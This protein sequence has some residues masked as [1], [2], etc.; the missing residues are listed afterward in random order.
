[1]NF[2]DAGVKAGDSGCFYTL[3]NPRK[4]QTVVGPGGRK[5]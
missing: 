3:G 5:P 2:A 1:M 4:L